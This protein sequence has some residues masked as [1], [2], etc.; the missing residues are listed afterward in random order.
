MIDEPPAVLV[1][2]CQG[3]AEITI[4]PDDGGALFYLPP[5]YAKLTVTM[6]QFMHEAF[7]EPEAKKVLHDFIQKVLCEGNTIQ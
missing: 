4:K 1:H 5:A 7:M 2:Y 6:A 3:E